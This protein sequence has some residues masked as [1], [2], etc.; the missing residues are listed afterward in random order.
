VV[1][2]E[3]RLRTVPSGPAVLGTVRGRYVDGI[4]LIFGP[5]HTDIQAILKDFNARHPNLL[6]TTEMEKDSSI[7]FLD[8]SI[9]K[10]PRNS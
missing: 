9:Q 2:R 7:N 6:F 8:V 3:W 5:I 10:P 1:G 4:L